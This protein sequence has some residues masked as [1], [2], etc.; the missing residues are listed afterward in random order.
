MPEKFAIEP[1]LQVTL[2]ELQ[3]YAT[4]WR[5]W[6]GFGAVM[7]LLAAIGPFGTLLSMDVPTRLLYWTVICLATF[8]VGAGTSILV[9]IFLTD[10]RVAKWAAWTLGGLTGGLPAGVIAW[11]LSTN[12]FNLDIAEDYSFP[13]FLA[14][15]AIISIVVTTLSFLITGNNSQAAQSATEVSSSSF[16]NRLPLHLGKDLLSLE[17][18]DHYLRVSTTRGS[19]LILLR[20]SDAQQ[21]LTNYPGL[22]VHRSWWVAKDAIERVSRSNGRT[23]LVLRDNSTVPVSR[24]YLKSL[25]EF[26]IR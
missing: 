10:L 24:T 14:Y 17:A 19:E 18:H 4:S 15:A 21:E 1:P 7:I 12:L 25:K 16:F 9:G 11:L 3:T 26:G 20:L 23:N 6:T 22:R 8:F 13:Q 5:F 2:R